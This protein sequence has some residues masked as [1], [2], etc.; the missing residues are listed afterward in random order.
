M[1]V[2]NRALFC[3][4]L[5]VST[6][7]LAIFD[8]QVLV[9]KRSGDAEDTSDKTKTGLEGTEI[10]AAVHIDPIPLVPVA[11]GLYAAQ[12]NFEFESGTSK[13]TGLEVGAQLYA[14]FPLGI[15]GLK[16]Y[17]KL[18]FPLYS[19]FKQDVETAVLT[20]SSIFKATGPHIGFGLGYGLPLLPISLLLEFDMGRQTIKEE[21]IKVKTTVGTVATPAESEY[22]WNSTAILFG[23]QAGL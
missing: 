18:G 20:Y 5:M 3:V 8:A 4:G 6:P 22:G 13:L 11:F 2:L 17:A 21:E 12:G 19:A 9:G 1:R 15:A 14:W 16:P 23:V 7:A 10:Q